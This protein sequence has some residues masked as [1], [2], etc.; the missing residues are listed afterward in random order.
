MLKN[1]NTPSILLFLILAIS[2]AS[3]SVAAEPLAS[4]KW[5]KKTTSISGIWSIVEE[6]GGARFLVLG[7]DFK[8]KKAPDLKLF[9][10]RQDLS[11]VNGSNATSQ[12]VL[13]AKLKSV[14][15]GQ[16]Y[17]IP[18]EIDLDEYST[19]ILHCEKY[20]K[21]WGGATIR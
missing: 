21:L 13:I 20:A 8:T 18:D 16:R 19:L 4:G 1:N 6:D 10:S 12:A 3:L 2:F 7:D 17:A 11:A 5:T 15:G 14:R 9:L